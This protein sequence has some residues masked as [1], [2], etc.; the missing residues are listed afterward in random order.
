MHIG[1]VEF[2]FHR[3]CEPTNTDWIYLDMKLSFYVKKS[4]FRKIGNRYTESIWLGGRRLEVWRT[5]VGWGGEYELW[6]SWHLLIIWCEVSPGCCCVSIWN[7]IRLLTKP[8]S[9]S[10]M[11]TLNC[12]F[13]SPGI[14]LILPYLTYYTVSPSLLWPAPTPPHLIHTQI[15]VDTLKKYFKKSLHLIFLLVYCSWH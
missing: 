6:I 12:V 11:F 14:V 1:I 15:S 5:T 2:Q 10:A 13:A 3:N 9:P 4:K 7:V 8:R